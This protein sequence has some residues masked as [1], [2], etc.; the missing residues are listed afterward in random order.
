M[1]VLGRAIQMAEDTTSLKT[2]FTSG[3]SGV[4][5]DILG[6]IGAAMPVVLGVMCVVVAVTFGIKFFKKTT[7]T[8]G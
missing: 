3:I 4:K 2:A 1:N 8:V 7:K 5:D 6:Y